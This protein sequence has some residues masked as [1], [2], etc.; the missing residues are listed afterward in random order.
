MFFLGLK[1]NHVVA[2]IGDGINDVLALKESDSSIALKNGSEATRN[3]S[4]VVILD[5]DF[6]HLISVIKEGRRTTNN[7]TRSATLAPFPI[8]SKLTILGHL[9]SFLNPSI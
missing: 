6:S 4:E 8:S 7:I 3:I 9:W 2:Y 1:E 5:S